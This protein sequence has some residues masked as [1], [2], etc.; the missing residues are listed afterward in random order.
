MVNVTDSARERLEQILLEN[1][2]KHFRI[3]VKG[4]G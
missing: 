3:Y 4:M 2:G 1:A